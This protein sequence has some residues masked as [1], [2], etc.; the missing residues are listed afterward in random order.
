MSFEILPRTFQVFIFKT[1]FWEFLRWFLLEVFSYLFSAFPICKD[2]FH[3]FF[4]KFSYKFSN[5]AV[6]VFSKILLQIP[7][8]NLLENLSELLHGLLEKFAAKII[9]EYSNTLK[10]SSRRYSL[11]STYCLLLFPTLPAGILSGYPQIYQYFSGDFFTNYST[12]QSIYDLD[13][14]SE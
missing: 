8:A 11:C 13:Q 4:K 12:N 5:F 6:E 10:V 1:F 3:K 14:I 2:L 9:L 7:L